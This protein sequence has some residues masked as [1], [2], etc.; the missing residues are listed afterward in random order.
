MA[1]AKTNQKEDQQ[2]VDFRQ[3]QSFEDFCKARNIDPAQL[4]GVDNLPEEFREPLKAVYRLM[5]GVS[6]VNEGKK[7]DFTKDTIKHYPW[8]TVLS[9]G[10][11]F[12]FSDSYTYC[13]NRS[14]HVGSRLCS[15]ESEKAMHVFNVLNDDYKTWLI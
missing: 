10:S 13:V 15:D 14:S 9:S 6:A 12:D 7:A 8:A 1:K 5:V 11:G 4:P 3:M 2:K